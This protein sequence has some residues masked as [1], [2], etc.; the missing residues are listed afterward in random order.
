MAHRKTLSPL[1]KCKSPPDAEFELDAARPAPAGESA[2]PSSAK[3]LAA[4]GECPVG[5]SCRAWAVR[6]ERLTLGTMWGPRT[7]RRQQNKEVAADGGRR[8]TRVLPCRGHRELLGVKGSQVQILSSRQGCQRP[9]DWELIQVS[10]P[11]SLRGLR[12]C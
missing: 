5:G 4:A 12:R 10:G 8:E 11:F 1:E 6:G 7:V 2:G 3:S 9:A